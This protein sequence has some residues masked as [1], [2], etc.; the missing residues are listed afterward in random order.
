MKSND[1]E[2]IISLCKLFKHVIIL[3]VK[4]KEIRILSL[5]ESI[6]P[7]LSTILISKISHCY[8]SI[9]RRDVPAL[10][11]YKGEEDTTFPNE[12]HSPHKVCF[13]YIHTSLGI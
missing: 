8:P 13:D 12:M 9:A 6:L 4:W 10:H 11:H 3:S 2:T 7:Q 1:R 5:H